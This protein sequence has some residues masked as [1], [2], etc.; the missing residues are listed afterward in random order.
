MGVDE[1][2]AQ[3]DVVSDKTLWA[4]TDHL[5]S[6]R[7]LVDSAGTV[8]KHASY[9]SFG[10]VQGE[11]FFDASGNELSATDESAVDTLFGYTGRPY[12]DE[13]DLQNNLHRWYDSET[14]R[15]ISQDPIGFAAGDGNLYRYVSN[16]ST[17]AVDPSGLQDPSIASGGEY[18]AR[19]FVAW[20]RG[21]ARRS[22]ELSTER[23]LRRL[24]QSAALEFSTS[25]DPHTAFSSP[26]KNR[27]ADQL[28]NLVLWVGTGYSRDQAYL[29]IVKGAISARGGTIHQSD[30]WFLEQPGY[31]TLNAL[32]NNSFYASFGFGASRLVRFG[33]SVRVYRVE[34]AAEHAN[35]NWRKRRCGN[36]GYR[37]SALAEF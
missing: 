13:T 32:A 5:G 19:R 18:L 29:D 6:V 35:S 30:W 28:P 17:G 22:S 16:G 8:R 33:H 1:L 2:L 31:D 11:Q 20:W 23:H 15:W 34:G 21:N 9:D 36:P 12:D 25:Y 4:L 26:T 37:T 27:C 10:N 3:D 24:E 14:G 7:D